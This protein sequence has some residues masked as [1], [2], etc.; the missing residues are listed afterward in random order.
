MMFLIINLGTYFTHINRGS[1]YRV[2]TSLKTVDTISTLFDECDMMIIKVFIL[3]MYT[4][5]LTYVT[6]ILPHAIKSN[7]YRGF[8]EVRWSPDLAN[9][10]G[11]G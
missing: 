2:P 5:L 10:S 4:N 8:S 11:P 6:H 9:R 7:R 3:L 1:L